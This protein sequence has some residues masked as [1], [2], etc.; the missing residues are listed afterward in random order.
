MPASVKLKS[1]ALAGVCGTVV[2][3]A[4]FG[5]AA[6]AGSDGVGSAT[7][8]PRPPDTRKLAEPLT[9]TTSALKLVNLSSDGSL[10]NLRKTPIAAAPTLS[11]PQ[12][13]FTTAP[14]TTVCC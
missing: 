6:L 4:G 13:V 11:T 5:V 2:F 1:I 10:P 8:S 7:T 9:G 3:A 14:G 12:T